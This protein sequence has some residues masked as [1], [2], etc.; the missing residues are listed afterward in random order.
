MGRSSHR[1]RVPPRV[2]LQDRHVTTDQPRDS[3]TVSPIEHCVSLGAV[4]EAL[5]THALV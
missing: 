2:N 5:Q 1:R 4:K 3:G